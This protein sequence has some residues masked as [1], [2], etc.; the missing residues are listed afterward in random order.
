MEWGQIICQKC[1]KQHPAS[2]NDMNDKYFTGNLKKWTSK[3]LL[4][5]SCFICLLF[6]YFKTMT[7]KNYLPKFV[8]HQKLEGT[9]PLGAAIWA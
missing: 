5:K 8:D 9:C 4:S 6:L 2:L 7:W 1:S 3:R